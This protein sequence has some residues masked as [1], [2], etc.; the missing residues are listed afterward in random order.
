MQGHGAEPQ[1]A[2]GEVRTREDARECVLERE[3]GGREIERG[4][5]GERERERERREEREDRTSERAKERLRGERALTRAR[6]R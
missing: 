5:E 1:R 4:E 6:E 2:R 3:R